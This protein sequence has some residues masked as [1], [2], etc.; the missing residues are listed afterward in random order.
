MPDTPAKSISTGELASMLGARLIGDANVA[1]TGLGSVEHAVPGALTFIRTGKYAAAWPASR[2]AAAIVGRDV[3]VPGLVPDGDPARAERPLLI[4]PDADAALSRVLEFFAPTPAPPAPGVNPAASVDAG[5]R[6]D[7]S[8]SI[9]PGCTILAGARVGAGSVFVASVFLGRDA[10]VGA[11][12]TLHAGVVVQD[13]CE[14][15]G[16]CTLHPNVVIGA[17]GFGYRP[18]PGGAG[19]LKVPH[20]GNVV[21]HDHVEI[22]AGSCVDR[23]KFGSTIVGAGTKIDNLV[24]VGHGCRIGRSCV[25]CGGVGLAGSVTLGDGV[26]IGGNSGV[27]DNIEIGAGA[28]LGA[29]SG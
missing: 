6:V 20:I 10:V 26:M 11:R 7:P 16:D 25:I 15:G 17:D 8:A 1:V 12:T 24:Q 13:R 4:V 27:A 23:A 22:G 5:A 19:L 3:T 2:A 28:K 29:M 21:I 18:A 9:G 14:I